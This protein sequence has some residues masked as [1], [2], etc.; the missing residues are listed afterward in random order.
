VHQGHADEVAVLA[1]AL[2]E[3]WPD[4]SLPGW[5]DA[6]ATAA[7]CRY[8]LGRPDEAIELAEAALPH[9]GDAVFAPLTL[10]RVIAQSRAAQGDVAGAAGVFD[11]VLPAARE[12]VPA[13]AWEMAA[14]RAELAGN[15]GDAAAGLVTAREVVAE[16]AAAGSEITRIW[17]ASVEASL[18]LRT[19]R[20][21]AAEL[22][23]RMLDDARA[24]G[25]SGC[26]AVNLHTIAE[27]AIEDGDLV[28]AAS[29]L[30]DLVDL[31][32]ARGALTELR[33]ALRAAAVVLERSGHPT[34][35]D[36]AV[37]AAALPSVSAF[38]IPGHER[39][40]LS[41]PPPGAGRELSRREAVVRLREELRG[42][43]DGAPPPSA[44]S[45]AP[46]SPGPATTVARFVRQGDV[47]EVAWS[48]RAVTVRSSKGMEDLH[49]LLDAA[50]R[51]VHCLDLT[52]AVAEEAST[53]A[54][55]DAEARRSYEDRIRELQADVEEAEA[56][57]D[58]V[59]AERAQAEMDQIVDHLTAALG[60][61]GEVRSAAGSAEKARSAV[62]QR[63]R[64]T[65]RRI[66][67]VHPELG[68]HLRAS[69]RTGTFCA[70]EPERPTE[71]QLG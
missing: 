37:T 69:I 40:H 14:F 46:P 70:Y 33:N 9:V 41:E 30:L 53:G 45:A 29:V 24:I 52:G 59:R 10:R 61:R 48:G 50:G 62:T 20:T 42:V 36:L 6:A 21:T 7:T 67:D 39:V 3:R 60:R 12:R 43:V 13:L 47:W 56:A 28:G 19:D 11:E 18:L 57:N 38:V 44:A 58:F 17:A 22:A 66:G 2:L 25:F 4:P 68:R 16:S 49:V 65:I 15:E 32:A 1:E 8:L 51:E 26:E 5:G 34:W 54:L 55:I 31:L 35:V 71:W 64:A 23:R 27:A 63:I